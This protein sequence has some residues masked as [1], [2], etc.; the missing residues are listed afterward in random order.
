MPDE[1]N[2]L[3]PVLLG[4]RKKSGENFD[5]MPENDIN[6]QF[7][8]FWGLFLLFFTQKFQ[9][10]EKNLNVQK[11]A[12]YH[13]LLGSIQKSNSFDCFENVSPPLT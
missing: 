3:H 5:C 2:S 12:K 6:L 9:N 13:A 8:C 11:A 10:F 1:K 4:S 7:S